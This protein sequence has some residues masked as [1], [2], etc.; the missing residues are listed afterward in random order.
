MVYWI[1]KFFILCH[2]LDKNLLFIFTIRFLGSLVQVLSDNEEIVTRYSSMAIT[3]MATD[4]HNQTIIAKAGA[5]PDLIR[6]ASEAGTVSVSCVVCL[7]YYY[8]AVCI[9]DGYCVRL[10]T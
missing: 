7:M 3:N 4:A 6:L 8:C 1:A 9:I 5:L 10:T 2:L